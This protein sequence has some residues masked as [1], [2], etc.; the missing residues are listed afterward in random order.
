MSETITQ[1]PIEQLHESPFN[2]RKTFNDADLQE[3]ASDIQAHGRILQP[4]LVR[5]R[6]PELFRSMA[7]A[8]D[9]A[10][11]G[12]EIVFG[13]R[14]YRAAEIAGLAT[15]PCMV[16][17]MSDLEVKRAQISEN[18]QRKDVAPLEEAAG[19]QALI[20]DHG[21]TGDT[22]AEQTGKSRSY[23]YA[24]LKL[25]QL[26]PE[27]RRACEAGE[28]DAEVAGLIARLR[29]PKL[30]Q[31]A[32][33][34][35]N[36][37]YWD[38]K[39]GG[40]K[41]YRNIRDLLNEHFTLD[42]KTAPFPI[43]EEMLLPSAGNCVTCPKR[44]SNAPE[45]TDLLN[46]GKGP[47]SHKNVG[48]NVCTDPE[49][50]QQKK[51]AFFKREADE[52]RAKGKHVVDGNKA[53][54]AIDASGRIKGAYVALK[55]V[56]EQVDAARRV[57]QKDS[58]IAPPLVVT[59]QDPR[60]GKNHQAVQVA[61]LKAAG[62]LKEAPAPKASRSHSDY[63]REAQARADKGRAESQRRQALFQRV[64]A[65]AADRPRTM[66]E[67][68]LV[69]AALLDGIDSDDNERLA[70]L[71]GVPIDRP[72][73]GQPPHW[74]AAIAAMPAEQVPLLMLDC[75]MI[76]NTTV[77]GWSLTHPA[78]GLHSLAELYG[79]PTDD[80]AP[81]TPSPAAHAAKG[82]KKTKVGTRARL[83]LA[84]KEAALAT[85]DQGLDA[86]G[87][88][89]ANWVKTKDRKQ[90]VDAGSAGGGDA[91]AGDLVDAMEAA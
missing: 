53:R 18:L 31:K 52:L 72:E 79:I 15:L 55:D 23:V 58:K 34:Y 80:E 20:D 9:T 47:Y 71:W 16:R 45:F 40:K 2:P 24:R 42:L 19:F 3:L 83:P 64:R 7:D 5:P 88:P 21:E 46:D 78:T 39:D 14:R 30:Q 29:L 57:A 89:L 73:P 56:K 91:Q 66:D 70:E 87:Q 69:A 13:H 12:F 50:F 35:I 61:D 37:K 84:R 60:T 44:S 68:R 75:V 77:D 4:L 82:A 1:I 27:V 33:G 90:K 17:S 41:S 28:V 11:C 81:V 26:C 74:Q 36:G 10:A 63:E 62:V 51:V 86:M 49:C 25:L 22:I 6:I 54:A 67:A 38:L 43:E 65:A 32:L 59:I 76:V 48:P 8:A 85:D